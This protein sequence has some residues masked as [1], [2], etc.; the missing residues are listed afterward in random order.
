MVRCETTESAAGLAGELAATL[1]V[2]PGG[3]TLSGAF[4]LLSRAPAVLALDNL[5][6]PWERDTLA[7]EELLGRVASVPGVALIASVRGLERPSGVRW[8][9]PIQLEPLD[10]PAARSLFT[11]IAPEDFDTPALDDLLEEM[12]GVPL[13]VELLAYAADGEPDLNHL[14]KRWRKE[15]AR[16]LT[17]GPGDHR[18]LSIAVS[19]DTSWNSPAMTN[20][21]KRL[22]SILGGLPDGVADDDLET[23]LP[24]EGA[25][26]ANLLRRRGLALE[27]A[28]RLRTL[29]PVRHHLSDAHHPA[30]SDWRRTID[31][32]RK[33]SAKL[34]ARAGQAGGG[35]A[36]STLAREAANITVAIEQTLEREQPEQGY[37]AA[38]A[39]I[40]TAR[41]S[42]IDAAPVVKALL[43]TAER[44]GD[45]MFLADAT[46]RAGTLALARSD[47]NA[48]QDSC[49]R[50]QSLYEQVG[51]VVGR[52]NCM[53]ILGDIAVTRSD[54]VRA[55][56]AYTRVQPLYEQVGDVRGKAACIKGLG[57]I[58]LR[59][60]DRDAARDA[61]T[62]AQP[63][64]KQVGGM[65]GQANCI[66]RLGDIALEQSEYDAARDAYTRAQPLYEQVGGM[67][68][69]ANCIKGLGDIALRRSDH[70]AARDA[71]TR[72]QPMYEQ[73]GGVLG[74]ANCIHRLG[75]IALEQ[76][77]YDAARDAYTRAQ[78]LYEQVG[79]VLGQA[80]CIKGL[81]DIALAQPDYDAAR[82]AYEQALTLY[83]GIAEPYSI[84]MTR[85]RLARL[86]KDSLARCAHVSDARK[87]WLS[88]ER[89]DLVAQ[90][91]AE[92][93]DCV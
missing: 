24:G 48:A 7:V 92:F 14:A 83:T 53:R 39:F 74:Q 40:E 91:A 44:S 69:Q 65:L 11:S 47:H 8:G 54:H 17:R 6:T 72:A 16:L 20:A 51:D 78:P 26:A 49:T 89:D 31:H 1:G 42:G 66:Q 86:E 27:Q 37:A 22:L 76:S 68:G 34:G 84:G 82:D 67:L 32:Y 70:D 12:G 55:R 58:A 60:S 61:Y 41:F 30:E 75:D 56:D 36:I 52:A 3:D 90:L 57:D 63:L 43:Q 59:R 88:I 33:R 19:I 87:A 85:R 9:Q 5:E 35:E 50:A 21:A 62:R 46:F 2:P 29:P 10:L 4:A 13:A 28:G 71:Y 15:R 81:G 18:L 93:T 38:Y 45:A 64:Y 79:E 73:V 77:E 25:A 23:L 80:N